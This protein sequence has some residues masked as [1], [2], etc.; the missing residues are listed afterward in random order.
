MYCFHGLANDGWHVHCIYISL[1]NK[2]VVSGP[3]TT[4]LPQPESQPH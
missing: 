2:M 3:P 1:T 4:N